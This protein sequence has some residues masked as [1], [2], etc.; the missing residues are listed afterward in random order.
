MCFIVVIPWINPVETIG[1][2]DQKTRL[3]AD[4]DGVEE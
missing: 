3:P 1:E 2:V 4:Q